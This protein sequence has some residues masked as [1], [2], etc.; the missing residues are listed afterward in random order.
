MRLWLAI[1]L[2]HAAVVGSDGEWPFDDDDFER[3]SRSAPVELGP[4][5]GYDDD[6]D[7][8]SGGVQLRVPLGRRSR[9]VL[10]PSGD[11]FYGGDGADWQ[12]N[13]D[14]MMGSGPRGGLYLGL[15]VGWSEQDG[16]RQRG[17]NQVVGLHL[18]FGRAGV[19][20]Y[21]EG[22]WTEVNRNNLFRITVGL[23]VPLFRY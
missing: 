3:R 2:L 1:G 4:R 22:R 17:V 6:G 19:R 11:A 13:L 21:V 15:G 7:T 16:K 23:N 9:F 8:I 10:V 18:P 20:C 12:V 14:L 5:V